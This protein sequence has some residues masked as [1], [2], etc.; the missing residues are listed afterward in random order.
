MPRGAAR[1]P[2]GIAR[3]CIRDFHLQRA[4]AALDAPEVADPTDIEA[5]TVRGIML[6]Q[7]LKRLGGSERELLA[8]R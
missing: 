7:A 4:E 3:R 5:A 1:L 2:I 6:T 8:L